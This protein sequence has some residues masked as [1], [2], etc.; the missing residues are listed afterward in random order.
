MASTVKL[1]RFFGILVFLISCLAPPFIYSLKNP[2]HADEAL[3]LNDGIYFL[4][5]LTSG[6]T[7]DQK[8]GALL[9]ACNSIGP[10]V[11]LPAAALGAFTDEWSV[12]RL[13][14][15]LWTGLLG[16]GFFT[17][18]MTIESLCRRPSGAPL[19]PAEDGVRIFAAS[20]LSLALVFLPHHVIYSR[21]L[22]GEI[23][24]STL[25][26]W[27]LIAMLKKR[28]NAA[29]LLIG[30]A[31]LAKNIAA[32]YVLVA[33]AA[34]IG[35]SL[36]MRRIGK[37]LLWVAL[38]G[39][40]VNGVKI[41][42]YG[43]QAYYWSWLE[44][45]YWVTHYSGLGLFP[46]D[47]VVPV[48]QPNFNGFDLIYQFTIYLSIT[49]LPIFLWMRK[50]FDKDSRAVMLASGVF[51][52]AAYV[53]WRHGGGYV[54]IRRACYFVTPGLSLVAGL[55]WAKATFLQSRFRPNPPTLVSIAMIL[56]IVSYGVVTNTVLVIE[57]NVNPRAFAAPDYATVKVPAPEKVMG[58]CST[59]V[60]PLAPARP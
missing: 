40:L 26:V 6:N 37:S 20:I 30:C 1:K 41:I 46:T 58:M 25:L 2:P 4:R 14:M 36:P 59:F 3:A 34:F 45:L 8:A 51:I 13:T 48:M 52:L 49:A 53:F 29:A 9:N 38:P 15:T 55:L 16:L 24:M 22:I 56:C 54:W 18:L 17:M 42:A 10:M 50:S 44:Y 43:W 32:T 12:I 57:A 60:T 19:P 5:A 28:L 21:N 23:P 27:A 11:S 39:V 31:I 47:S 33:A 7:A 35:Q